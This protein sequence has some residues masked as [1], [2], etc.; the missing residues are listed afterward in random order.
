MFWKARDYGTQLKELLKSLDFE[1]EN[2]EADFFRNVKPKFACY[3]EYF[4]RISEALLFAPIDLDDAV[5]F[6]KKGKN[7]FQ[8][9]CEEQ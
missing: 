8:K 3:I 2:E 4:L 1:D 6:W 9:F 7:R 5:V